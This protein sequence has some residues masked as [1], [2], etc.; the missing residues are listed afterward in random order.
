MRKHALVALDAGPAPEPDLC[1]RLVAQS[2]YGCWLDRRAV[3]GVSLL[4]VDPER[5]VS[6]PGEVWTVLGAAAGPRTGGPPCFAGGWAGFIG[7]EAAVTALGLTPHRACPGP[8]VAL[9]HYAAALA[10]DHRTGRAW[11]VGRGESGRTA[12]ADW[13]RRLA[14]LRRARTAGVPRRVGVPRLVDPGPTLAEY[15][16]Q[17]RRLQEWIRA[18][19]TYVANLT[20][21]LRLGPIC[22]PAGAYG[23]LMAAHRAPLA[24]LLRGPGHWVLSC[25]PELFL[26]RRGVRTWTRPIKGTRA[27]GVGARE[28]LAADPKERA[29]LTMVV[30]MERND[31]GRVARPGSVR[32]PELFAVEGHPGLAHL[33]A[34]VEA[35]VARPAGEL[36][37]AMLPGGSVTGA[38]KR[39]TVE[40]LA[41]LETS[42]R[43]VYTGIIGWCD[44][45]GDMEWSVAIRTLECLPD[46]TLYGTGAGITAD[47]DA[48]RE[49]L[50]TRL[51]ARGPL[52][53]LG[54]DGV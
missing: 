26:A 10:I 22:D 28:L 9:G 54:V 48:E 23:C 7:Y 33:V 41:G 32:V 34:T 38:P 36:L 53:A 24:A 12:A 49:Y 18:G 30:D 20:Y 14:Q 1:L 19:E 42:A 6:D 13:L 2:A 11:A 46:V 35:E 3:G 21:R 50:E 4:M 40:L 52:R 15:A 25:S 17:V 8:A 37:R 47:S 31:L 43:G 5:V 45:G 39:R 16:A 51:K 29:E 27:A 44:D